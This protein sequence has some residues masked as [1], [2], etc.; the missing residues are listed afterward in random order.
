M[1]GWVKSWTYAR[2]GQTEERGKAD[3]QIARQ[4]LSRSE[5]RYVSAVNGARVI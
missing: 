4:K 2:D 5:F 3:I 1:D